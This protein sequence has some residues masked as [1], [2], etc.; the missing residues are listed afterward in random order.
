MKP[1]QTKR[2]K[3]YLE[4]N[5]KSSGHELANATANELMMSTLSSTSQ[6]T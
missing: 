4:L 1:E 3:S 5:S 6:T 2:L